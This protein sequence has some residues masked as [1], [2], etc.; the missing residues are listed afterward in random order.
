M[1]H[2]RRALAGVLVACLAGAG[3]AAQSDGIP[4]VTADEVHA[5][6]AAR[7][8][9]VVVVNFWASWCPPCVEE[10][11]DLIRFHRDYEPR[12]S[13]VLAV[14]MNAVDELDD[15]AEFL[16]DFET[17]FTVVRAASQEL[18]FLQAIDENWFG[19]MPTTLIFDAAG[20]PVHMYKR[21]VHYDELAADVTPL[22]PDAGP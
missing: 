22:L 3:A 14:S 15:V 18:P 9:K 17:P 19:E 4:V 8:G 11:P 6:I 7:A 16:D 1:T 13:E 10:F 5:L 2:I 20:A 12:G 21:Q